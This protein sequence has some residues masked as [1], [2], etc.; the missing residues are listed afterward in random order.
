MRYFERL[1]FSALEA[2]NGNFEARMFFLDKLESDFQW[3]L[4]HI[5]HAIKHISSFGPILECFSDALRSGWGILCYVQVAHGRWSKQEKFYLINHLE[6]L[7]ALFELKCFGT[8]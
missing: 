8:I 6:L 5:D 7:S 4:D 1:K 3:C 2:N